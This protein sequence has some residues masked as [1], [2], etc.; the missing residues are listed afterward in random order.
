MYRRFEELLLAYASENDPAKRREIQAKLWREFG[1]TRAVLVMD[2]SH[3][4]MLTEKYGIV[5]NLAIIRRMQLIA[6]PLIEA[7]GGTVIKFEA[8]N[9]FAMFQDVLSAIHAAISMH[10]AFQQHNAQAREQFDIDA[11]IGIDYGEV[12]LIGA[13]EYFGLTVNRASKLGEDLAVAGEIL[14]SDAAFEQLPP[15]CGILAEPI[16]RS[17]SGI[18]IKAFNIK[19]Q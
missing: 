13:T 15:D 17:I 16:E 9:C 2:L 4:S 1:A 3:F 19:Y 8:D 10:Q 14:V 6:R 12:L 7:A 11:G 18:S 5:Y